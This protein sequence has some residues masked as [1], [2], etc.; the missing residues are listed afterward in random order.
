MASVPAKKVFQIYLLGI[1]LDNFNGW[2]PYMELIELHIA[3][4]VFLLVNI[5]KLYSA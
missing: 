5:S 4:M 2:M 3:K 1:Y